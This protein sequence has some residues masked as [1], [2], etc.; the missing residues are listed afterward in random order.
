MKAETW[1]A[2]AGVTRAAQ[3]EAG[4]VG[5][6]SALVVREAVRRRAAGVGWAVSRVQVPPGSGTLEEALAL[7]QVTGSNREA[8]FSAAQR[9]R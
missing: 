4:R 6:S 2:G 8:V 1:A 7:G 9:G 5:Q 3:R